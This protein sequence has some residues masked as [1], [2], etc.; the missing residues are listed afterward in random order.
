MTRT[1]GLGPAE[2][3]LS[4]NPPR[5]QR[6]LAGAG[7]FRPPSAGPRANLTPTKLRRRRAATSGRPSR[8][9]ASAELWPR[10]SSVRD[11]AK[12]LSKH[13][14]GAVALVICR[15]MIGACNHCSDRVARSTLLHTFHTLES[16]DSL[17]GQCERIVKR[18]KQV[19]GRECSECFTLLQASTLQVRLLE[20][21]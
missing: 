8:G 11:Q 19:C 1:A 17:L 20:A 3:P 10:S 12:W 6:H 2:P 13:L 16:H 7:S 9:A 15:S 21:L 5:G 4:A 18:C 14:R